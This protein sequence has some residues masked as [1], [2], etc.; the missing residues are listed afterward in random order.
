MRLKDRY[1]VFIK[2]L[3]TK[4]VQGLKDSRCMVETRLQDVS[5]CLFLTAFVSLRVNNDFFSFRSRTE[6]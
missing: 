1:L 2:A 3:F 4:V 5:N 6:H